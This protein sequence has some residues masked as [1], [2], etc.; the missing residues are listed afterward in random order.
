L[1]NHLYVGH[2]DALNNR[3]YNLEHPGW[4]TAVVKL[5]VKKFKVINGLQTVNAN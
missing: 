3:E 5:N 1:E 4:L 2:Y